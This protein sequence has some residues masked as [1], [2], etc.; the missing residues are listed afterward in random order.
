MS[1]LCGCS[2]LI[3]DTTCSTTLIQSKCWPDHFF[4]NQVKNN[5]MTSATFGF[6]D[7]GFQI[8]GCMGGGG[9]YSDVSGTKFREIIFT[10]FFVKMISR[11][12]LCSIAAEKR[13]NWKKQW[14]FISV[15]L[16]GFI[17]YITRKSDCWV[18]VTHHYW[19][20]GYVL[21]LILLDDHE[22]S[23]WVY[24]IQHQHAHTHIIYHPSFWEYCIKLRFC[25]Y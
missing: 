4:F 9:R 11:N 7:K 10:K 21:G 6:C 12:F 17:G 15:S 5:L 25:L 13:R 23:E 18:P 3:T 24:Y 22:S 2:L 1:R 16:V 20:F 14:V 8:F 19:A